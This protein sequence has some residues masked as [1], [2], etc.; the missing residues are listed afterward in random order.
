[1]DHRRSVFRQPLTGRGRRCS[2]RS[3]QQGWPRA[4]STWI[5]G[6]RP[7]G[8][9]GPAQPPH[10]KKPRKA[11][12]ATDV[13]KE[14]VESGGT[15]SVTVVVNGPAN[16]KVVVDG[17]PFDNWFGGTLELAAGDHTFEFRPPNTECCKGP[18]TKTVTIRPG[19][20]QTV[21]G[22]IAWNPATHPE[23]VSDPA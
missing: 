6:R 13:P 12:V 23:T 7:D 11:K 19:E 17:Q 22:V 1:M 9:T 5:C 15:A 4:R 14:P 18:V 16:A 8:S 10:N 21:R 3:A 20:P 2:S